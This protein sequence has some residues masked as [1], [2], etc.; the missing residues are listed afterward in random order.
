MPWPFFVE[1]A[2]VRRADRIEI[3]VDTMIERVVHGT[4]V[5]RGEKTWKLYLFFF[6]F[7]FC[8]VRG[9][10]DRYF[11]YIIETFVLT[12]LRSVFTLGNSS[13]LDNSTGQDK[14]GRVSW[15]F[16]IERICSLQFVRI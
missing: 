7:S 13:R 15:N 12:R 11:R 10:I 9:S 14:D 1:S 3:V 6:F 16:L 2:R 4:V 5:S 8:F